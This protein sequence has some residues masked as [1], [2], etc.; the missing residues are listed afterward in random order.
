MV[1]IKQGLQP[2]RVLEPEPQ[3]KEKPE[4]PEGPYFEPPNYVSTKEE[5]QDLKLLFSKSIKEGPKKENSETA[6]LQ[7]NESLD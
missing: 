2:P 7:Q 4:E 6:L 1:D 3:A 5:Q